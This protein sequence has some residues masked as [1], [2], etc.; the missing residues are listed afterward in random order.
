MT[1]MNS[2]NNVSETLVYQAQMLGVNGLDLSQN[3]LDDKRAVYD[4]GLLLILARILPNLREV[5]LSYVQTVHGM[6]VASL[7]TSPSNVLVMQKK[8]LRLRIYS[9]G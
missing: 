7:G 3:P 9:K 4:N 5:N 6:I 1:N 8:W 2:L